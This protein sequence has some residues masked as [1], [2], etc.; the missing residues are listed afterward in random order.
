MA[1]T[2]HA[3]TPAHQCS[4]RAGPTG[5][6]G[7]LIS[8]TR[9]KSRRCLVWAEYPQEEEGP[10]LA[11]NE[12]RRQEEARS[13]GPAGPASEKR[14]LQMGQRGNERHCQVTEQKAMLPSEG[15]GSRASEGQYDY[16]TAELRQFPSGHV[17]QSSRKDS[18]QA[19]SSTTK[20]CWDP[21]SLCPS[22]NTLSQLA[23]PPTFLNS[24]TDTATMKGDIQANTQGI[25]AVDGS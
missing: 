1:G 23:V 8:I 11:V 25:T 21:T 6:E 24:E 14:V 17:S 13:T 10:L 4:N 12:P 16:K 22:S 18:Q 7:P 15:D 9:K 3:G 19:G 5:Q 2:R 20:G